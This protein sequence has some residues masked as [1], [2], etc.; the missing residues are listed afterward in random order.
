VAKKKGSPLKEGIVRGRIVT[1]GG[2]KVPFIPTVQAIDSSIADIKLYGRSWKAEVGDAVEEAPLERTIEGASTLSL[3]IKDSEH[4]LLRSELLA[5]PFDVELDDLGFT[6]AKIDYQGKLDPITLTF[7]DR[8]VARLRLQKGARKARREKVTRAEFARRLVREVK[9]TIPFYCPQLHVRQPIE[10]ASQGRENQSSKLARRDHGL[11]SHAK[12]TVKHTAADARQ[13][14]TIERCLDAA[15]SVN[16]PERALIAVVMCITQ[17]S[18]AGKSS[19]PFQQ[20]A[21][22][23]GDPNDLENATI[24]FLRRA[25]TYPGG[26]LAWLHKNPSKSLGDGVQEIQRAGAGQLYS[27]WQGEATNTVSKYLG[28][29]S[30][31]GSASVTPETTKIKYQ[32]ERKADE[33]TWDCISRLASEVNWRCFV[34]AGIVYFIAETDLLASK[35][36]AE[37]SS[38]T[39]GVIDTSFSRDGNLPVDEVTVNAQA[40]A[41]GAPP[42]S[43][44]ELVDHG[45]ADGLYIVSKISTKLRRSSN[46]A[47]ITLKRP[48]PPLPEPRADQ[49]TRSSTGSGGLNVR[50]DRSSGDDMAARAKQEID[51]MD[52]L[53]RSYLWG[54]GH[55]SFSHN[56]PWDC[57]GAVSQVLHACGAPISSPLVSGALARWGAAGPGESI[58]IY[59]N[60]EH[61]FMAVKVNGQWRFAGT[62]HEN[63]G[64]GFGW[65]SARSRS[66]FTL[67]HPPGH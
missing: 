60:F 37:I 65:H 54:G 17:E 34:A 42:G 18:T 21:D 25:P 61:V 14:R 2:A 38:S 16:S 5:S 47:D 13:I 23:P 63:P 53:H 57:S 9:P 19:N 58:T 31:G 4:E 32:F 41:W 1:L 49:K 43:V 12:I 39:P 33:S 26:F 62:S 50:S 64:G 22:W 24:N 10:T 66:G 7:E 44:V 55:G 56:G 45:P 8:E 6:Y 52:A 35:S 20:N 3:D 46:I 15:M 27:Q 40:R 48:A 28:G 36:R 67:R 29:D 51:R 59:A 30:A 11:G